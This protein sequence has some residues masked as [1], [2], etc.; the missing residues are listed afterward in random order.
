L[1]SNLITPWYCLSCSRWE[2]RFEEKV[3]ALRENE[4]GLLWSYIFSSATYR[5]LW[6][7]TPVIVSFVTFATM[8]CMGEVITLIRVNFLFLCPSI[9]LDLAF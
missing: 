1:L 8:V 2:N 3:A 6:T 7:A 5:I 4:L 9:F